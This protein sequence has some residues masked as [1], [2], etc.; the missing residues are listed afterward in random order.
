VFE[1]PDEQTARE[2]VGRVINGLRPRFP[3]VAELLADAEPD[4]LTHFGLP[5][6]TGT[7]SRDQPARAAQQGD[8]RDGLV[9]AGRAA[10]AAR[11]VGD[12]AE[13]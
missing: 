3:S 7:R 11:T 13:V 9:R 5:Q 12:R 1:R 4:L 2:Q 10:T 6:L 8:P